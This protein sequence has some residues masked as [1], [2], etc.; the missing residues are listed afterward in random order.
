MFWIIDIL[1]FLVN[2]EHLIYPNTEA[3][4]DV[5]SMLASLYQLSRTISLYGCFYVLWHNSPIWTPRA[6][7]LICVCVF[8]FES[9]K[10]VTNRCFQQSRILITFFKSFLNFNSIPP[11]P[12][13][14]VFY[15]CMKLIFVH[16]F[17]SIKRYLTKTSIAWWVIVGMSWNFNA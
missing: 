7:S 3:K 9:S 13:I 11:P 14:I 4:Y 8:T 12:Q 15:Q 5:Q 10:P 2:C 16:C 17:G 1:R 6:F